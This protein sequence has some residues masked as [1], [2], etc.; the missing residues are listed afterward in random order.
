VCSLL[1]QSFGGGAGW[2]KLVLQVS[3]I[4]LEKKE[5]HISI[6]GKTSSILRLTVPH[7][8]FVTWYT[9]ACV[10]D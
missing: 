7:V 10:A 2:R 6:V 3:G 4:L 1:F 9:I 8:L 5:Q